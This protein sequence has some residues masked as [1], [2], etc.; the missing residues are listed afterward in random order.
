MSNCPNNPDYYNNKGN[1]L[2]GLG[3]Y[4]EALKEHDAAAKLNPKNP[5]YHSNKRSCGESDSGK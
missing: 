1:T 4:G 5:H 2:Y 3:R